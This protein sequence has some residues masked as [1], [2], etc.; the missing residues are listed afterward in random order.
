[1]VTLVCFDD[2]IIGWHTSEGFDSLQNDNGTIHELLSSAGQIKH[3]KLI[4][5]KM[6]NWH[7][8]FYV[9]IFNFLII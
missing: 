8:L 3:K 7:I 4:S 5:N 1:M 6:K 2:N 9:L